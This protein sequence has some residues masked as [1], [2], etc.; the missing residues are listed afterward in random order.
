M[1]HR[2][3]FLS[4]S[5]S[6][7]VFAAARAHEAKDTIAEVRRYLR[8]ILFGDTL[9]G[10]IRTANARKGQSSPFLDRVLAASAQEIEATVAPA[11]AARVTFDEARAIA[12]FMSSPLGQKVMAQGRE[13]L[14]EAG[15][16]PDLSQAEKSELESFEQTP[17][18]QLAADL[19]RNAEVQ[20][21]YFDL[22]KKKYA[23]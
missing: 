20:A 1:Y 19:T 21:A 5:L 7:A 17:A 18:G 12:D 14:H 11:F 6:L 4:A 2:R 9:Q 22:L 3:R 8:A 16:T 10:G 23:K 13:H 15:W